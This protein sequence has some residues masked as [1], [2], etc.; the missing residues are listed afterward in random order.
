MTFLTILFFQRQAVPDNPYEVTYLIGVSQSNLGEP[1]RIKMNEDI[2]AEAKKHEGLKVIFT[3]AAQNSQ[4]QVEDI[5]SLIAMGIDLLIV[6]PN[7]SEPLTD[8]VSETYEQMPVIVL[9]RSINS[10]DYTLFIGADNYL[11]GQKAGAYVA[12][13]AH[14]KP[15]RILEIE[16]LPGSTPAHERSSGFNDYIGDHDNLTV[17]HTITADWLRDKA[18]D[19]VAEKLLLKTLPSF[20]LVYA[21]NDPMALGA[22]KAATAAGLHD[23]TYIGI[24]A[25][26][27]PEGG[28]TLVEEGILNCTFT[29]PTGGAEAIVYALEILGGQMPDMKQITLTSDIID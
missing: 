4:K 8:I 15:L 11:I 28:I 16:G 13:V 12:N 23:K 7:E 3:D 25:L 18:E 17:V 6:S 14:G 19:L 26:T 24:D 21:H 27:G 9:D 22:Y 5:R 10:P 1:W 2:M 29:Y 20:D